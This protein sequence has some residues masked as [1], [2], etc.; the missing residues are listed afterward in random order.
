MLFK[1]KERNKEYL[2]IESNEG[3]RL[4]YKRPFERGNI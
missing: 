4:P 1:F 3:W 2:V